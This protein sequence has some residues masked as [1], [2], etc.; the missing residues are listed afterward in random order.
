MEK[1]LYNL[2]AHI[3]Q[4]QCIERG[5]KHKTLGTLGCGFVSVNIQRKQKSN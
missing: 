2:K 4:T 3:L 5:E 1:R